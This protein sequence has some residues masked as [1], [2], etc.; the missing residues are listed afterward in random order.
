MVVF[1]LPEIESC[2]ANYC[3][4]NKTL[5]DSDSMTPL[6][7]GSLSHSCGNRGETVSRTQ[8]GCAAEFCCVASCVNLKAKK[9]RFGH[10]CLGR[11]TPFGLLTLAPPKRSKS[12]LAIE[13][14]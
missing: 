1:S 5:K 14:P 9:N 8:M 4:G 2:F 12:E 7:F 13:L 10:P 6:I 3:G 11:Q